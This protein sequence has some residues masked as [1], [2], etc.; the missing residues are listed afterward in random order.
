MAKVCV[1]IIKLK[2]DDEKD[3]FDLELAN[4]FEEGGLQTEGEFTYTMRVT[5]E[6]P[7]KRKAL[8]RSIRKRLPEEQAER[9]IVILNQ[10]NWDVSF[11]V[12]CW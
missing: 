10:N 8:E 9:I 3:A 4:I 12:D 1:P 6:S 7:D 11:F 5:A 2:Y